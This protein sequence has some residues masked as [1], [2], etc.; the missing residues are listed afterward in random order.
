[1][2]PQLAELTET[3]RNRYEIVIIIFPWKN[4]KDVVIHRL[5]PRP[6]TDFQESHGQNKQVVLK[7]VF[8]HVAN[9]KQTVISGAERVIKAHGGKLRW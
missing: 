6:E 8:A 5:V 4:W 7:K 1:M 3:S 9:G 2:N